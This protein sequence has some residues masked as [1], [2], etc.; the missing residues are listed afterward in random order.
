MKHIEAESSKQTA[1]RHFTFLSV[2]RVSE[3]KAKR[4]EENQRRQL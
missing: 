4:K 3:S 1:T 2:L